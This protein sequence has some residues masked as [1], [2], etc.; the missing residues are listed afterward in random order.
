MHSRVERSKTLKLNTITS[1]AYQISVVI[2]GIILPRLIIGAYGSEVNGLVNSIN[3]FLGLISFMELGVGSVVRSSLYKPLADNDNTL[4]SK[5]VVSANKF[6]R[7]FAGIL[8]VYVIVLLFV[9]PRISNQNFEWIF[10]AALI[11]AISLSYFS[12][13]YFGIVD[14]LLLTADQRGY[15][16]YFLQL[17]TII[18]NTVLCV[19]FIYVGASIQI[20]KLTT[21]LVYLLRPIF[22]RYYVNRHYSIDRKIQYDKEPIQQKWN[23]IAQHIAYVIL[24]GTDNVVL[25]IFSTLSN[26][27]IYS[28]YNMVV[29]GV[30]QLMQS[31]TQGFGSLLGELWA[32]Q[33]LTELR[34][35]F[36][37]FEWLIH[38]V[39]VF[40]F[41]NTFVLI[42]PFVS[43]YTNGISDADYI[44]PLFSVLIVA[45]NACHCLRLPYNTMIL[46]AGHYR[47]TQWNFILVAFINV[48]ISVIMVKQWGLIGVSIGTLVAMLFQTIWMAY[49]NY[50]N[51]LKTSVAVFFK[52]LVVDIATL[53]IGIAITSKLPLIEINYLMWIIMALESVLIWSGIIVLFNLIFYKERMLNAMKFIKRRVLKR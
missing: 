35:T 12:Q 15:I 32:R 43:V 3:Q 41:G 48:V 40:L 10:T 33:D 45:A 30:K 37:R 52:H 16:L 9:Y 7:T 21:S 36:S 53:A 46:S 31:T 28:M 38:T 14:G 25:T 8:L 39:T 5:I 47:Q 11:A 20:V 2:C 34:K 44:Q 49:Y 6:F 42:V 51:I 4:I 19:I 26:V 23:G 27:S 13:Y 1:I 17:D 50:K 24:E 22:L 18:L 29:L